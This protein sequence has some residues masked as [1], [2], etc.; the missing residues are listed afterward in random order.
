MIG[1]LKRIPLREVWKNE[2]I[3]FTPWLQE[4]IDVLNE[5]LD[6]FL[7]NPEREQS[8]GTFSVDLGFAGKQNSKSL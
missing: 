3:D 4:N 5:I 8:A 1:K 2:A 7:S 6:L